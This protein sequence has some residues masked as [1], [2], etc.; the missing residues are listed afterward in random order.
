MNIAEHLAPGKWRNEP[1]TTAIVDGDRLQ[2]ATVSNYNTV[3]TDE[4]KANLAVM[5]NSKEMYFTLKGLCD[6]L[7]TLALWDKTDSHYYNAKKL[8]KEIEE[9][10]QQ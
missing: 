10:C 1:L 3:I 6:K 4:A 2:I 9:S 8:L 7:E 5:V